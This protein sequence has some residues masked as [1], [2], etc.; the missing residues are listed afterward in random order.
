MNPLIF[1]STLK[2]FSESFYHFMNNIYICDQKASFQIE[3]LLEKGM[4]IRYDGYALNY[5]MSKYCNLTININSQ[6]CVITYEMQVYLMYVGWNMMNNY[7]SI[8]KYNPI[9]YTNSMDRIDV[10]KITPREIVTQF[11]GENIAASFFQS[12][13]QTKEESC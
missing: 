9:I 2:L 6:K 11:L 4:K 10:S 7:L 5:I 12:S 3:A 13:K 8:H 1:F